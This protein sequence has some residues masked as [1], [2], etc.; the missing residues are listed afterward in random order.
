MST[1]HH[2][3]Y[4]SVVRAAIAAATLHLGF[5][6]PS[7]AQ[8]PETDFL[9]PSPS[10]DAANF[11]GDVAIAG[12]YAVIGSYRSN[13]Y[14]SQAGRALVYHR[15]PDGSWM[16]VAELVGSEV[17]EHD[18][19]G[20][21]VAVDASG[22]V[23]VGAPTGGGYHPG[24][25]YLF[26][27]DSGGTWSQTQKVELSGTD[28]YGAFGFGWDV[29]LFGV[30]LVVAA[31]DGDYQDGG[32]WDEGK[33]FVYKKQGSYWS[34][35][36]T[37][38]PT[39]LSM[40]QYGRSA[41]IS[42]STVVAGA[43]TKYVSGAGYAG[44]AYAFAPGT[45][46]WYLLQETIE[47]PA[48]EDYG[49]F[50]TAVDINEALTIAVG[51]PNEDAGGVEDAG[52]VHLYAKTGSWYD[53]TYTETVTADVLMING[54]FGSSL[55]IDDDVLLVGAAETN[56][57]NG[58]AYIFRR[59]ADTG[60]WQFEAE[61]VPSGDVVASD[62]GA[63]V[64]GDGEAW[65]VG[66][67][68]YNG[69]EDD[70]GAVYIYESPCPNIWTVD[71]DGPA[72]FET[73]QAAIDAAS[74]GDTIEIA[75][76]QYA[77]TGAEVVHLQGKALSL[78]GMGDVRIEGEGERRGITCTIPND[79]AGQ[80]YIDSITVY[81]GA[82]DRG[83]CM[84]IEGGSP[85]I[86]N[87]NMYYGSAADAGGNI[88]IESGDASISNGDVIAGAANYGGGVYAKEG[89]PHLEG[90]YIAGNV[91][92]E[93][94]G[95][96]R[97]YESAATVVNCIF[98]SNTA[99]RGGGAHMQEAFEGSGADF[100]DC[101]FGTNTASNLGGGLTMNVGQ[102]GSVTGC[103]F[104]GNTATGT[105]GGQGSG[106]GAFLD[107]S[108]PTFSNCVFSSNTAVSNG[109]GLYNWSAAPSVF[110]C[111]FASCAAG[112]GP[113]IMSYNGTGPLVSGTTACGMGDTPMNGVWVDQGDNCVAQSCDDT[114]DNG[115]PDECESDCPAD[116]NG[117]GAVTIDDLLTIIGS[118]G[119][120][121]GDITGD[122]TTNIEDLLTLLGA[123]GPCG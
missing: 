71:D 103:L 87:C 34:I 108:H 43:K 118:W 6:S 81:S 27:P 61:L 25:V 35:E 60:A 40:S 107:S 106:G 65:L 74:D 30:R 91:A 121:G 104:N 19:F 77:G 8:C 49:A 12:D 37:L 120:A 48:G 117:D 80:V 46:G 96:L 78:L 33:V 109:G 36:A 110:Y 54:G 82:A 59:D 41:S 95:G 115:I 5:A 116:L 97:A 3:P 84:W 98:A 2:P 83:G 42:Y 22:L 99:S 39:G 75:T 14:A 94:G 90:L 47:S 67:P 23:A 101:T 10:F 105:S 119:T 56:D 15:Q 18:W 51:A 50:G 70:E 55:S 53:W 72:D 17:V 21:S 88:C 31:P 26:A 58:A 1:V 64:A 63:A 114:N 62:F 20:H 45:G 29:D 69:V 123:Y 68:F 11:G 122:G 52:A 89:S 32:Q 86:Q 79:P 76:G 7:L 102:S 92:A 112:A 28:A 93:R 38:E 111:S 73:I 16:H 57:W 85:V 4:F 9:Q 66:A 113:A 24:A 44:V 100:V 13:L